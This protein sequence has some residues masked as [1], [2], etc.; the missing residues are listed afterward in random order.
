MSDRGSV[1]GVDVS[2]NEAEL[3][4]LLHKFNAISSSLSDKEVRAILRR[5]ANMTYVR[6]VRNVAPVADRTLYTYDTPKLS[7][8]MRAPKGQGRKKAAYLPG[9]LRDSFKVLPMRRM[10]RGILIG[11][12]VSRS[13]TGTFGPRRPNAFYAHLVEQKK[14]FAGPAYL[15][16]LPSLIRAIETQIS[17]LINIS[18]AA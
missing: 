8:R 9:N 17:H 12:K 16:S 3:S 6:T 7:R 2:F 14:P 11:P 5:A 4:L 10:G 1:S 13:G 18:A 15:A